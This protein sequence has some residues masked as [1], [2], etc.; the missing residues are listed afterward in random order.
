MIAQLAEVGA[1]N[2]TLFKQAYTVSLDVSKSLERYEMLQFLNDPYD[3]EGASLV[4]KARSNDT[5]HQ[6]R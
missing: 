3:V 4:I 2:Y 1:V 6:V 5:H